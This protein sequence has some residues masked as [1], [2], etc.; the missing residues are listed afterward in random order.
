[1]NFTNDNNLSNS[2]LARRLTG[3]ASA[4]GS[5]ETSFAEE[6]DADC[7]EYEEVNVSNGSNATNGSNVA[8]N[9]S[10][11]TNATRMCRRR[12][13]N[14]GSNV[15]EIPV[16]RGTMSHAPGGWA[17][18]RTALATHLNV[19]ESNIQAIIDRRLRG[20]RLQTESTD[21]YIV[22]AD[23]L[24]DGL[25]DIA[26]GLME[27]RLDEDACETALGFACGVS[28]IEIVTSFSVDTSLLATTA[29]PTS[30]VTTRFYVV[31]ADR[32][33]AGML[34]IAA[35]LDGLTDSS[36]CEETLGF[37]CGVADIEEVQSYSVDTQILAT[38]STSTTTSNGITIVNLVSDDDDVSAGVDE[39]EE[40][41]S[42]G[43][44]TGITLGIIAVVVVC[45]SS[46]YCKVQK[47]S[48]T[49]GTF[50]RK[51]G[52]V[53]ASMGEAYVNCA[54]ARP[55]MCCGAITAFF[56]LTWIPMI[57]ALGKG[58]RGPESVDGFNFRSD[59]KVFNL[60]GTQ[61]EKD[62]D[63]FDRVMDKTGVTAKDRMTF[64][65]GPNNDDVDL[66]ARTPLQAMFEFE[67]YMK[68]DFVS[69]ENLT[70][71][72]NFCQLSAKGKVCDE[73]SRGLRT[74]P[75]LNE[76]GTRSDIDD[77]YCECGDNLI[78]NW[79]TVDYTHD[80][81]GYN[82]YCNL[83]SIIT[84]LTPHDLFL[85]ALARNP[86][87][88]EMANYAVPEYWDPPAD[89][90]I[91]PTQEGCEK[92]EYAIPFKDSEKI[93]EHYTVGVTLASFTPRF[94]FSSK[95]CDSRDCYDNCEA[96]R[97]SSDPADR[98]RYENAW[99]CHREN[100]CVPEG[101][102]PPQRM[103]ESDSNRRLA[104]EKPV[105]KVPKRH[106]EKREKKIATRLDELDEEKQQKLKE[107]MNTATTP[108]T[109]RNLLE[110]AD[111]PI[112]QAAVDA[113]SC[114]R[115]A[116]PECSGMVALDTVSLVDERAFVSCLAADCIN[117]PSYYL[118][119]HTTNIYSMC[120][121]VVDLIAF[122]MG[123]NCEFD[124][125]TLVGVP[126]GQSLG[127]TCCMSCEAMTE[128]TRPSR[129]LEDE[130]VE[131]DV[132][133]EEEIV[134]K[135]G[136]VLQDD[137]PI[138]EAT[139]APYTPYDCNG[140]LGVMTL[141]KLSSLS[142]RGID[143]YSQLRW[144]REFTDEFID[145][146]RD[147]NVPVYKKLAD[148]GVKVQ[149]LNSS[150]L[151]S[152][153]LK[154]VGAEVPVLIATFFLMIAFVYLSLAK[155]GDAIHSRG[156]LSLL[157][158]FQPLFAAMM[159]W[160]LGGLDVWGV[161][162]EIWPEGVQFEQ[163]NAK[164]DVPMTMADPLFLHLLLAIVV[165]M[166]II[167]VRAYDRTDP[168]FGI[169]QRL[170][171]ACRKSHQTV[172]L[173]TMATFTAFAIGGASAKLP[174]L[175]FMC[176]HGALGM[177]GLYISVWGLLLPCLVLDQWRIAD[178]RL[179][180]CACVKLNRPVETRVETIAP[181][182]MDDSFRAEA[183]STYGGVN[184]EG[185]KEITEIK[186][187][188]DVH[189]SSI[190]SNPLSRAIFLLIEVIIL[191]VGC[192]SLAEGQLVTALDIME[193]LGPMT[194]ARQ[195]LKSVHDTFGGMTY[196]MRHL[197]PSTEEVAYNKR[198]TR[199]YFLQFHNEY[200]SLPFALTE[201][202]GSFGNWIFEFETYFTGTYQNGTMTADDDWIKSH[203]IVPRCGIWDG[204]FTNFLT[205]LKCNPDRTIDD[206]TTREGL[207]NM[208]ALWT[209]P[210][211]TEHW[212]LY[213][214]SSVHWYQNRLPIWEDNA[215]IFYQDLYDWY[216]ATYLPYSKPP[217]CSIS[218]LNPNQQHTT[219]K[220][221]DLKPYLLMVS[222]GQGKK[223]GSAEAIAWEF[224]GD[225]SDGKV[226]GFRG[227]QFQMYMLLQM[228]DYVFQQ[229]LTTELR[230]MLADEKKKYPQYWPASEDDSTLVISNHM[231]STDRDLAMG[232]A[233]V[234]YMAAI[235]AGV[236]AV[237]MVL[238]HPFYGF[239]I[240]V[241]LSVV[242][243]QVVGL[244]SVF[245]IRLDFV[246]FICCA[247]AI[248]FAVEYVVHIAWAYLQEPDDGRSGSEKMASCLESMGLSIFAAFLSTAVQ[249]L[250]F[251][252]FA[253]SGPFITF[254]QVMLLV[255][256]KSGWSGF[257]FVPSVLAFIDD[258]EK[259]FFP[260]SNH[261]TSPS[262]EPFTQQ[263]NSP[264]GADNDLPSL[265]APAPVIGDKEPHE[266]AG[267]PHSPTS[268]SQVRLAGTPLNQTPTANATPVATI[269]SVESKKTVDV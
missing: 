227:S 17:E 4:N 121:D 16:V 118:K 85:D 146:D 242:N 219:D 151:R 96:L 234:E 124:V 104:S 262:S 122:Q 224:V 259:K 178:A 11:V 197:T 64:F 73:L 93:L 168:R 88:P 220:T 175:Q 236:V 248:A 158:I 170:I 155:L 222:P 58:F 218:Y 45:F 257:G 72:G 98:E 261:R 136:R 183:K 50:G 84:H 105:K 53:T 179:D 67:Q 160:S 226:S 263:V 117:V 152:D 132:D 32:S 153:M 110:W 161:S 70:Y 246:A 243:L 71:S 103:I 106:Q 166:D 189:F 251:M 198:E 135:N 29:E 157:V 140:F 188:R 109:P 247:N 240:G 258:T 165:D 10:N 74:E 39:E 253:Q 9:G 174:V 184:L 237:C 241:F 139:N 90:D 41:M 21:F 57:I 233:L 254:C 169:R 249:Q 145:P 232:N 141:Q 83:R 190:L 92:P 126:E 6:D 94:L 43:A 61:V 101:G 193:A 52:V 112:L 62:Y 14:N 89:C 12:A 49:P 91:D 137:E 56:V 244:M 46:I 211:G 208:G 205:D 28:G 13:T 120:D 159:A 86:N 24:E 65:F 33:E 87:D 250:V 147:A 202:S 144:A 22:A 97:L 107:W 231:W 229:E 115:Q 82:C 114:E 264:S 209:H 201:G 25:A 15:E 102:A 18:A 214:L 111:E 252:F 268:A 130:V 176:V 3:N 108:A 26:A 199:L 207:D 156:L 100:A 185:V 269:V 171:S 235:T 35:A 245:G 210:A 27:L 78:D 260:S 40:G 34:A 20:R 223:P 150:I 99:E 129:R 8:T 30:G 256:I 228:S 167:V 60:A 31:A 163:L 200:K 217:V 180:L 47:S 42:S 125:S 38:T 59:T 19:P 66:C 164:T 54:Y 7:I 215:G 81:W 142:E 191:L 95:F 133:E 36:A 192:I 181:G 213:T 238:L 134:V 127:E 195:V 255:V 187:A 173:S 182:E 119:H 204:E 206:Y 77:E 37:A 131:K 51:V 76:D 154:M 123:L 216:H 68:K 148:A 186:G 113:K 267:L 143:P 149:L 69:S 212:F 230:G 138:C 116:A 75:Q 128:W 172:F 265:L 55:T 2:T 225:P 63:T 80:K 196:S 203:P 5:N 1:L 44:A 239:V 48:V 79:K 221:I 23:R 162:N 266:S 177:I 194:D